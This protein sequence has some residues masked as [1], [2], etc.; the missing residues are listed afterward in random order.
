MTAVVNA[1]PGRFRLPARFSPA[2]LAAGARVT[3]DT[4]NRHRLGDVLDPMLAHGL[5]AEGDLVLDLVVNIAGDANA[6]GLGKALE[7]GRDVDAIPIDVVVL[8][9]NV[10]DVDPEPEPE[11]LLLR[12]LAISLGDPFLDIDRALDRID[13]ARELGEYPIAGRLDDTS[14]VLSKRAFDQCGPKL[15]ETGVRALLVH[16]HEPAITDHVGGQD[17][18]QPAFDSRNGHGSPSDMRSSRIVPQTIA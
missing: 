18:G 12:E 11:L 13:R 2:A 6:A 1:A 4:I 9:D 8:D 10:S 15:L 5:K 7:T 3:N 16:L 17:R 14:M